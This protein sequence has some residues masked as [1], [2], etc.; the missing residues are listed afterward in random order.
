MN[1]TTEIKSPEPLKSKV[2]W[3]KD[4]LYQSSS[5]TGLG[6]QHTFLSTFI[7]LLDQKR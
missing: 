5:V 1:A 2:H 6:L 4:F 7:V 3:E